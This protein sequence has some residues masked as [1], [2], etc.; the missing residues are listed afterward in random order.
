[1]PQEEKNTET[2]LKAIDALGKRV[3]G[4]IEDVTTQMKQ[5]SAMLA[6]IAKSVQ[7]NAK[8]VDECK[9]TTTMGG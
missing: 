2:I 6:T 9:M 7:L 5:H 3:D 4:R 1:M 8:E